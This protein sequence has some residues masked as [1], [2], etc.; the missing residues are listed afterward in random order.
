[1]GRKIVVGRQGSGV[2]RSQWEGFGWLSGAGAVSSGT[3]PTKSVRR[4]R[5]TS[6]YFR[7]PLLGLGGSRLVLYQGSFAR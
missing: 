7:I 6:G 3:L 1:M 5:L 4:G 2:K